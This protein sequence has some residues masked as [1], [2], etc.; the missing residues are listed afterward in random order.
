MSSPKCRSSLPPRASSAADSAL[1]TTRAPVARWI[2]AS[3]PAWSAWAWLCRISLRSRRRDAE[4]A[5]ARQQHV[6]G[7]RHAAVDQHR[8]GVGLH[9]HRAQAGGADV[10]GAV[11]DRGTARPVGASRRGFRRPSTAAGRARLV[12]GVQRRSE[13][14]G[15]QQDGRRQRKRAAWHRRRA[16]VGAH[17]FGDL[18]AAEMSLTF[19][20]WWRS[21][22][23]RQRAAPIHQPHRQQRHRDR[24]QQAGNRQPASGAGSC[25]IIP[26]TPDIT[27]SATSSA[28]AV[29]WRAIFAADQRADEG[30]QQPGEQ[31]HRLGAE[32]HL[33]DEGGEGGLVG[34]IGRVQARRRRIDRMAQHLAPAMITAT[35]TTTPTSMPR[36]VRPIVLSSI[37]WREDRPSVAMPQATPC[38]A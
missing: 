18:R 8:A 37:A 10:P 30:A 31:Q 14:D 3:G 35:A 24:Q 34:R 13:G 4:L 17:S 23:A 36:I 19:S 25:M 1:L 27:T 2:A 12:R 22:C 38:R 7:L 21:A 5:H 16:H 32:R 9:Q 26:T 29:W 33:R 28:A 11:A 15:D 20:P 6:R